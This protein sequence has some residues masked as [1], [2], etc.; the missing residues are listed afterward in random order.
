M[1]QEVPQAAVVEKRTK[2][3]FGADSERQPRDP[4]EHTQ[5]VG[6]ASRQGTA[7]ETDARARQKESEKALLKQQ[8]VGKHSRRAASHSA[9]Q[10]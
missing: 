3:P 5:T 6:L 9:G 2:P 4:A 8:P 7:T 1:G 10:A